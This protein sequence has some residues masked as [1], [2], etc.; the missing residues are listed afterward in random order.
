MGPVYCADGVCGCRHDTLESPNTDCM[1]WKKQLDLAVICTSKNVAPSRV[2]K[3][4]DAKR[5]K[6]LKVEMKQGV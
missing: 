1:S 6:A 3:C 4:I 5:L 2:A